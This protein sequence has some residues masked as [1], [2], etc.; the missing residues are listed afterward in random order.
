MKQI[1]NKLFK[2]IFKSAMNN[3]NNQYAMID[4]LN[5]FPVP[6][7][8]TGTNMSMTFSYGVKEMLQSHSTKVGDL[9]KVLSKGLLMGAR[10]N[11]GVI[12]SQIFRGFF[13]AVEGKEV[14][15]VEDFVLGFSNGSQVAYKAVMKPVEGTILTVIRESSEQIAEYLSLNA[16]MDFTTYFTE[17]IN[18][19]KVSLEN[20]PNLLPVLK[21]VGVVDSGGAGLV[22][23]L[24][25]LAA[26]INGAAIEVND[27]SSSASEYMQKNT[28]NAEFGYCTEFIVD[29][30]DR[31]K[32]IFDESI[33]RANLDRIGDSIVVV[34]DD[35]IV[36][37]HVH[38]LV[39]GDVL[40]KCHQYGEFI[41]LKIE[42]M[43]FQH[44][45]LQD[46]VDYHDDSEVN[47]IKDNNE[48][49]KYAIITVA[50]GSGIIEVFKELNVKHIISGGQTMNPA[51]EDFADV[52]QN[53]NAEQIIILPN[54][55]NIIL[56]A[57]QVKELFSDLD[58]HV[59]ETK[60]IPQGLAACIMFDPD[61]NLAENLASMNESIEATT[62]AQVTYAIKDTTFNGLDIKENE[63]MGILEKNIVV[64]NPD[65][66]LTTKELLKQIINEDSEILT[67]IKGQDIT[68]AE[69][70]EI[71]DYIDQEFNIELEVIH[72][73]QPV[74]SFIFG[75]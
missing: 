40:N 48:K 65:K 18:Y 56:A 55:S 25:G 7:G 62:T 75:V 5:V 10:G 63:F 57:N 4:A 22:I 59:L 12:L 67:L 61:A 37:V 8:D 71:T 64:S 42:N 69:L 19:A 33:L 29:L 72:G 21:E 52:I 34:H 44:E 51:T 39:P 74:Y 1:D 9:A 15:S 13:Q 43:Q 23:V 30:N 32:E 73:E 28:E 68:A 14:I 46:G 31:F 20:T 36:K 3:L 50:A 17:F 27:Q 38:T 49:E 47:T 26:A 70:K 16:D 45:N 41:K 58:I 53:I 66:I 54:N 24:E 35:D 2:E 6:D 11:S 60:S